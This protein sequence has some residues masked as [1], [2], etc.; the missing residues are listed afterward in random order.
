MDGPSAYGAQLYGAWVY[1]RSAVLGDVDFAA[2]AGQFEDIS[3]NPSEPFATPG[4]GARASA[5]PASMFFLTYI[6]T[7]G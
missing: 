5:G 2:D 7:F 6:I 4:A 1:A 3:L